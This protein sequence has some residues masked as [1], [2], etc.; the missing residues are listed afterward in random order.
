LSCSL[1][2]SSISA[3]DAPII[4]GKADVSAG[5]AN[6]IAVVTF[7]LIAHKKVEIEVQ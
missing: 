6:V 1:R 2:A 7:I 5:R 3:L 4:A